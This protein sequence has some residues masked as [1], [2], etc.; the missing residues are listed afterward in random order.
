MSGLVQLDQ[1]ITNRIRTWGQPRYGFWKFVASQSLG[2]YIGLA[3]TLSVVQSL[4]FGHFV[5]IMTATYLLGN[6]L[7]SLIKRERPD[8]KKLT[9]YT[10]WWHAYSYPSVHAATSAAAALA[11]ILLTNFASPPAMFV[12]AGGTLMLS[13]LI[14]ISRLVVGV[15]FAADVVSGWVLGF[16]VAW[17]YVSWLGL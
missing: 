8:F 5:A 1:S 6:I 2:L 13:W 17:S 3:L 14:G 16:V 4:Q 11:L 12:M 10:M 7:Q 15:H 9:G